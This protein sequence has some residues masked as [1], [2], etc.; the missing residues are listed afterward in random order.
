ML[1]QWDEVVAH[2]LLLPVVGGEVTASIDPIDQDPEDAFE[3]P[4]NGTF[5][6]FSFADATL[7]QFHFHISSENSVD[8][9]IFPMEVHIV[10]KVPKEEVPECGDSGC[11]VVFGILYETSDE[12]NEFLEPIMEAAP[13]HAGPD[14]VHQLPDNFTL[15]LND[16]I[17][18]AKSYYTWKGSFTTP[19]CTEGVLW[20]L[21]DTPSNVSTRQVSLLQNK[22]AL[23]RNTCQKEA[24]EEGSLEK[25]KECNFIGDLKNNRGTQRLNGRHVTHVVV[26]K[27]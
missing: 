10:T 2:K 5:Q 24:E 15:N 25:F 22:M 3:I 18:E 21:F 11:I 17:P 7:L 23:V 8:G 14:Y 6:T 20:I 13:D 26:S 27:E 4:E 1:V 19:P 16:L 9:H 12:D